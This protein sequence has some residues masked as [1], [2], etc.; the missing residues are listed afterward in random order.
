M[1]RTNWHTILN[2]PTMFAPVKIH[3]PS[4]VVEVFQLPDGRI[5]CLLDITFLEDQL[6]ALLSS[7]PRGARQL[8]IYLIS[9]TF[10]FENGNPS[11]CCVVGFHTALETA[12][13]G[14]Q[15]FIQTLAYAPW[16]DSDVAALVLGGAALSDVVALS[17]EIS[18]WMND[19]FANNAVTPS[20]QFPGEPGHCQ[21]NLENRRPRRGSCASSL[22]TFP[23]T[24]GGFTYHPQNEALL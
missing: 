16:I 4:S 19:P 21:G 24:I 2:L 9:N 13:I 17:H 12:A 1:R 11:D 3:V 22:V 10:L 7:E 20:W 6:T 5:F 8:R 14:S 23:V 18:E 15:I